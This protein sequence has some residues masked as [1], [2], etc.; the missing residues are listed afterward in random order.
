MTRH[1]MEDGSESIDAEEIKPI[2]PADVK[3]SAGEKESSE[4]KDADTNDTVVDPNIVDWDGPN[5]PAN[6]RNWSKKRKLLNTSLI[7]LSVLYSYVYPIPL[8][9]FTYIG[10]KFAWASQNT[11]MANS[12]TG[13][14]IG[15]SQ[16]PCSPQVLQN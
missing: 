8:F 12:D 7:S 11:C 3:D 10:T 2:S 4:K 5:D 1:D 9:L 14:N 15:I 16:Q 13:I 6:P